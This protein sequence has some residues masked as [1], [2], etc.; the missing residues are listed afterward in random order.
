MRLH[1]GTF[2]FMSAEEGGEKETLAIL[3]G[4]ESFKKIISFFM[5]FLLE[6]LLSVTLKNGMYAGWTASHVHHT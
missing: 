1:G 6:S 4:K 5:S 3:G 2:Q